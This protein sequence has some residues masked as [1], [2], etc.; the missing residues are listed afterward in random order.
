MSSSS[1]RGMHLRRN[2]ARAIV[3]ALTIASSQ[4]LCAQDLAQVCPRRTAQRFERSAPNLLVNSS[5]VGSRGWELGGG[6]TYD[7]HVSRTDSGGSLQLGAPEAWAASKPVAVRSGV[8]YTLA[9]YV[10]TRPWPV[11]IY[12]TVEF[13][14]RQGKRTRMV[15]GSA[16]LT[17]AG[18]RWEEAVV[19]FTPG[20]GDVFAR[21]RVGRYP[22]RPRLGT[23]FSIGSAWV[24]DIY[25]GEGLSFEAPPSKKTAFRGSTVR[26]DA[27]GNFEVLSGSDFK[28]F[29]P[30]CIY[31]TPARFR[32]YSA[33]GYNCIARGELSLPYIREA[34]E[35]TSPFNPRGMMVTAEITRY[36]TPGAAEFG[37]TVL[38]RRRIEELVRSPLSA[39]VLSYYWDDEEYD[40]YDVPKT[41]TTL[42]KQ[43][44]RDESGTRV[45]PIYVIEG[46]QGRARAMARL[47]DVVGDYLRPEIM[48]GSIQEPTGTRFE[49]LR[50]IEGQS[51]PATI[52][53]I[54]EVYSADELRE[55]VYEAL[56]AGVRGLAYYRDGA[57]FTDYDG[58]P[59]GAAC[60]DATRRPSWTA[61]PELRREID[62]WLPVLREPMGTAWSARSSRQGIVIGTRDHDCDAYALVL[63]SLSDP[64]VTD[65]V[66]TGLPYAATRAINVVSGESVPVQGGRFTIGLRA[67]RMAIMR[68]EH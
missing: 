23:S 19:S 7:P 65:L 64:T 59:N 20:P 42:V 9:A 50:S 33:Q 14:D 48:R 36:M 21:I 11:Q 41:I 49:I 66:L 12:L 28:P 35:A 30:L 46:N 40:A 55:L 39:S 16:Q 52:G 5:W 6:A 18:D 37:D 43:A 60:K 31:G 58:D 1:R 67:H 10:R 26:V 62:H 54:S 68:L 25:F 53:V 51:A 57:C 27:D 61:I 4:R 34:E 24:D 22:T 45:H 38:L 56:I 47:A 3:L 32:L 8:P 63:N 17:T 29:F 15:Q 13:V 2:T 44:D